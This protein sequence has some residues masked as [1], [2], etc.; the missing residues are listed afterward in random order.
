MATPFRRL[1]EPAKIKLP[2]ISMIPVGVNGALE[3]T[4][5]VNVIGSQYIE[6][7]GLDVPLIDTGYL[8]IIIRMPA[9]LPKKLESP[10]Y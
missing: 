4:G 1:T 9:P 6:G 10:V 8:S 3:L 5:A 7:L 2:Y